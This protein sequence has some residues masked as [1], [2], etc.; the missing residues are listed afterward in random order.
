MN[1][2]N[3]GSIDIIGFWNF[4]GKS[5]KFYVSHSRTLYDRSD[6]ISQLFSLWSI[7][8]WNVWLLLILPTKSHPIYEMHERWGSIWS[9]PSIQYH[10]NNWLWCKIQ[11]ILVEFISVIPET[12][13]IS[14]L[15]YTDG[16]IA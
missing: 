16:G 15:W 10:E 6:A 9:I 14:G 8:K 13:T 3:S 4:D 2:Q 12:E 11:F 1:E 7:F 5:R